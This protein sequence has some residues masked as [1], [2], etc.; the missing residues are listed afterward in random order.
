MIIAMDTSMI[1]ADIGASE[2]PTAASVADALRLL[3]AGDFQ[4]AVLDVNLGSETSVTVA[5]ALADRGIP[6]V[7]TTGY[8]DSADLAAAYPPCPVV[9]KPISNETLEAAV[10]RAL[11]PS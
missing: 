8:G 5:Q 7:L 10:R 9:Q 4:V 2:A 6:F 1:L 3:S 11:D